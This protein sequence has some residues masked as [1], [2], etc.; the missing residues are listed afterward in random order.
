[1]MVPALILMGVS[2][3]FSWTT[4]SVF[5]SLHFTSL[6][7]TLAFVVAWNFLAPFHALSQLFFTALGIWVAISSFVLF[8][9][10]G[11]KRIP[12]FLC[13]FGIGIMILGISISA[14]CEQEKLIAVAPTESFSLGPYTLKNGYNSV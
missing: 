6:C 10:E 7:L 2:P 14:Y 11:C 13:H 3:F 8:I 9:G 4:P 5:K 1:M 12:L